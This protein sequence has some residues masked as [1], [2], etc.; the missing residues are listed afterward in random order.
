MIVTERYALWHPEHGFVNWNT[1]YYLA[2]DEL[3][4][5]ADFH[6]CFKDPIVDVSAVPF[7]KGLYKT[8]QAAVKSIYNHTYYMYEDVEETMYG[9]GLARIRGRNRRVSGINF[10][11]GSLQVKVVQISW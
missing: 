10:P 7:M 1:W 2:E 11:L 3:P 5:G 9:T 6:K 4:T 8:R